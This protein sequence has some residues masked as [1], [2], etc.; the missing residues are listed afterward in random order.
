MGQT[1]RRTHRQTDGQQRLMHRQAGV[2]MSGP[3]AEAMDI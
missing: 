1:D 3:P 2:Q